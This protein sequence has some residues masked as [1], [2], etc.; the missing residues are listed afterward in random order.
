MSTTALTLLS[1]LD[2]VLL[3]VVLAIALIQIRRRLNTISAGLGTLGSDLA[4]I[5]S[6]HLR[7][8][9]P[10]VDQ[11]NERLGMIVDTLVGIAD[12]AAIVAA[13]ARS[14]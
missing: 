14:E 4:T 12:K 13:H 7:P 2:A 1:L 8:L 10:N 3:V 5:E 11:I 9:A 6:E